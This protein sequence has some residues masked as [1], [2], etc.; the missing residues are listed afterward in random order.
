[1]T[2]QIPLPL[3]HRETM[4]ADDLMITDSNREAAAWIDAWPGWKAHCLVIFG[5]VGAGKTHLAHV[6]QARSGQAILIADDLAQ[7]DLAA[8]T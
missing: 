7:L 5:P 3:P 1:M 4:E 2:R 8:L 6:W